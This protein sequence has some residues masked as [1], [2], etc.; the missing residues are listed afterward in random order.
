MASA[1][2]AATKLRGCGVESDVAFT[3]AEQRTKE[4]TVSCSL[5]RSPALPPS[6]VSARTTFLPSFDSAEEGEF[7]KKRK[8]RTERA[9][10]RERAS[11]GF[12]RHVTE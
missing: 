12:Y 6:R 2:A 5:K 1:S 3:N 10:K 7:E 9:S 4:R 11:A 8:K